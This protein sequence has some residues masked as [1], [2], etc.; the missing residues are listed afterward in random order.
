MGLKSLL[1]IGIKMFRGSSAAKT[2]VKVGA[3]A[4]G[5]AAVGVGTVFTSNLNL[6]NYSIKDQTSRRKKCNAS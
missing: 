6:S 4:I 2:A 3:A 1:N 5:T